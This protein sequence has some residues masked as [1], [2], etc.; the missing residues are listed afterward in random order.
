MLKSGS[1]D[2][3]SRNKMKESHTTRSG[4]TKGPDRN[5]HKSQRHRKYSGLTHTHTLK[6]AKSISI[7]LNQRFLRDS[8]AIFQGGKCDVGEEKFEGE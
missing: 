6:V 7:L 3:H 2:M 4:E 5:E 1:R 8:G